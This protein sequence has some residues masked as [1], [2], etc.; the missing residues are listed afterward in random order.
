MKKREKLREVREQFS[1]LNVK[2]GFA[3]IGIAI[4]KELKAI[5]ELLE[6]RTG[7]S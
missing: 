7:D 2:T 6:A 4:W 1:D 5:R 3:D